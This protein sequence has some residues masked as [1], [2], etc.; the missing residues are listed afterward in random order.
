MKPT[1][2]GSGP[3]LRFMLCGDIMTGRGIDQALPH[4]VPPKI[5]EPYV[6]DARRYVT[7]AEEANGAIPEPISPSYLWGDAASFWELLS[8]DLKIVN[9]ETSVTAAGE[10]WQGKDIHYRMHP[11]NI[12]V[13]TEADIDACVLANNHALDWGYVG[14][15][16]TLA[17]LKKAAIFAAGAG[18]TL[19]AAQKPV[20]LETSGAKIVLFAAG[21]PDAGVSP[22]WAAGSDTPGLFVIEDFSETTVS[23]IAKLVKPYDRPGHVI[24]FSL[25]WGG[26]WGFEVP[27][28]HR[29]FAHALIDHAGVDLLFGHSSHHVKGIEVYK[30]RL[31]L[32]GSGDLINDYEGIGGYQHYRPDLRLLYF[33]RVDG[34]SG[35]L[36]EL[37]MAP[38]TMRR[39]RLERV[40]EDGTRWLAET[41]TR[42]GKRFGTS[43][44]FRHDSLLELRW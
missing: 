41:L 19:E 16:D 22:G 20:M 29:R 26:N 43:V 12:G 27:R 33:P 5:Y 40:G 30:D 14:L 15:D 39:F 17:A 4:S 31:I 42:E 44:R 25:H 36:R 13:L 10:P 35:R 6:T 24:V 38:L 28:S 11:E 37:L 8:P 2:G 21:S 3:G 23:R 9:L 7:L 32:Y 18:D 1:P 34:R